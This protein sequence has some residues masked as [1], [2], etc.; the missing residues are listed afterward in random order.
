MNGTEFVIGLDEEYHLT[1]PAR[2]QVEGLGTVGALR[3]GRESV[4]E[5]GRLLVIRGRS[6]RVQI[7]ALNLGEE[8]GRLV[9]IG[10]G[11]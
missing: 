1:V 6:L 9:V 2:K 10:V 5:F 7:W 3:L 4:E 11:R 8:I